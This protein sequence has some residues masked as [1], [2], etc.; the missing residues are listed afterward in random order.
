MIR[1][2]F[3]ALAL[4]GLLLAG[5]G[6]HGEV[7]PT[8]PSAAPAVTTQPTQPG[9]MQTEPHESTLPPETTIPPATDPVL[10]SGSQVTVDG[11]LLPG[12]SVLSDGVTYVR[13]AEFLSAL[14]R[15]SY[16]GN[17]VEGFSLIWKETEYRFLPGQEALVRNDAVTVL[18]APILTRLDGLWIPV[19]EVCALLGISVLFD[20]QYNTLYCTAAAG[21]WE[22]Q[23]GVKIPV[24][25]YHGVTDSTWGEPELFV[26]PSEMEAQ[27]RYLVENGY[28][29]ITFEDWNRL[30]EF[31]K[32]VMLTFDDGYLDNYEELF[33]I[34]Q[35][36][37]AKAT[38]FVI[39]TSVDRDGRTM[40]S[41]QAREMAQSGLVS[42][43]SHTYNH[44]HLSE[45]DTD[46]L[47][48]QMRWSYYAIT[49]MTGY[50]P[51]VI[52]YPYGDSDQQ[53]RTSAMEYY[54]FGLNMTG[55][56]YTTGTDETQIT[57]FY[58]AR[59]T[60]LPEFIAMVEDAGT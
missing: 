46:Q 15:A 24:L 30:E 25:M 38:I 3:T 12:G 47:E 34:L 14:D 35:K 51:F 19:E 59:S 11:D 45:C 20:E 37:N 42:I 9:I 26:S 21:E 60:S 18:D 57:R 31:D 16:T 36:Y 7:M 52:C 32:P 49:R 55:G 56:L 33:P 17:A 28:D 44:P 58:V 22:F 13:A 41:E 10:E 23:K 53:A 43:Q 5:C 6:A 54:R 29:T 40:T 39:T 48:K 1:K 4:C 8:A 2:R 50:E 27:I